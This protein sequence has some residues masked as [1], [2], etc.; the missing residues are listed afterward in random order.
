MT[1]PLCLALRLLKGSSTTREVCEDSTAHAAQF[2]S[3]KP[4]YSLYGALLASIMQ[5]CTALALTRRARLINA[6]NLQM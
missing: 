5:V 2:S 6:A 3:Y 4:G 1:S